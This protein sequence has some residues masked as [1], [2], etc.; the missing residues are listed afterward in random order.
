MNTTISGEPP[1]N[2]SLKWCPACGRTDRFG[3][4]RARHY[5]I[6][7]MCQGRPQTVVYTKEK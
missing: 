7:R 6:G 3:P 1:V 5:A 2:V 4:L